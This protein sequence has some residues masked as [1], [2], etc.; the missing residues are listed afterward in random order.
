VLFASFKFLSNLFSAIFPDASWALYQPAFFGSLTASDSQVAALWSGR[1]Q[2]YRCLT[3]KFNCL[4]VRSG[5][6]SY[7]PSLIDR[8]CA[9]WIR[10]SLSNRSQ[11]V[12][13]FFAIVCP[14][15][16]M[17]NFDCVNQVDFY[18]YHSFIFLSTLKLPK[19][20]RDDIIILRD[21]P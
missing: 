14:S 19:N 16:W 5:V 11:S 21:N 2:A 13:V 10:L 9:F 15:M 7:S 3:Q 1:S 12:S 6:T 4:L 17:C 8:W 18:F 20:R